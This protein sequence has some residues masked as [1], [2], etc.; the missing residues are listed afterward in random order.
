MKE[1]TFRLDAID[2]FRLD[3][4]EKLDFKTAGILIKC[5]YNFLR[6]HAKNHFV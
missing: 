2:L 5:L 1:N 4:F 6:L 3:D